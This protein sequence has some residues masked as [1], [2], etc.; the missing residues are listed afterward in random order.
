[1]SFKVKV[2]FKGADF[3][4]SQRT[5]EVKCPYCQAANSVTLG[6]MQREE[7]ITCVGCKKN[8]NFT[9]KDKSLAKT[10]SNVDD[11]MADLKKTLEGLGD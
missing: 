10:V 8:F 6:Q 9:D 7:T 11:A 3:D 2:S 4:I 5:V 1:M